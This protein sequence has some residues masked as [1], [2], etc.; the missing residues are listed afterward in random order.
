V[1]GQDGGQRVGQDVQVGRAQVV[2]MVF[3]AVTVVVH[4]V[5]A[6]VLLEQHG[7]GDVDRQADHRHQDGFVEVDGDRDCSRRQ[8]DS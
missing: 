2:V 3:V 1:N 5:V 8:M 7:A 4:V 6:V